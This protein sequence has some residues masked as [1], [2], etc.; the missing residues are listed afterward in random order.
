MLVLQDVASLLY[1]FVTSKY[2]ANIIIFSS[3]S[4]RNF[5]KLRGV[6]DDNKEA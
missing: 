4:M 1:F 5:S 6:R 2:T 3:V